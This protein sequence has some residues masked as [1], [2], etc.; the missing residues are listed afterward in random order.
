MNTGVFNT[1][2]SLDYCFLL[3]AA[4]LISIFADEAF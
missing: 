3:A 2:V 4:T 1:F